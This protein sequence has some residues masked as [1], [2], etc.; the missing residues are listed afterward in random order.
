MTKEEEAVVDTAEET[1]EEMRKRHKSELR[2]RRS[3]GRTGRGREGWKRGRGST[4]PLM[5]ERFK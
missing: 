4:W 5:L 1:E 2:V 3:K